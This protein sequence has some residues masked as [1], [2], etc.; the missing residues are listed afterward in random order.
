MEDKSY[1]KKLDSYIS[2]RD[3]NLVIET[4]GSNIIESAINL[5]EQI[6]EYYGLE[7]AKELEKRLINSIKRSDPS[8]FKRK[9]RELKKKGS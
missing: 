8:K 6:N 9:V 4:R 7:E 1:L 3:K 2:S 5:I